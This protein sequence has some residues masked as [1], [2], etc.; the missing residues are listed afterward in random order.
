[1]NVS[2]ETFGANNISVF[3]SKIFRVCTVKI[4][5]IIY[6]Q[7]TELTLVEDKAVLV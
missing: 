2:R 7:Y 3:G 4:F 1:M 6:S 5:D